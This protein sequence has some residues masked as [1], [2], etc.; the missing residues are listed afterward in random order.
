MTRYLARTA[1][2]GAFLAL[3]G[4]MGQPPI[5]ASP[6]DCATLIPDSWKQPVPGADIPDGNTVGEWIAFGD[7]Q[8]AQLDK[9]N[10]RTSDTIGIISRCEARD[11]D[12][13]KKARPKVLGI[14]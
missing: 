6:S 11:R 4:C 1:S 14:F 2:L 8:T 5:I 13:V 3:G 7:A 10:G 12:A 9:A